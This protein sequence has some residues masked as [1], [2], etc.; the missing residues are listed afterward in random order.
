MRELLLLTVSLIV[1]YRAHFIPLSIVDSVS[2]KVLLLYAAN[3]NLIVKNCNHKGIG[4]LY[5][6]ASLTYGISGTLLSVLI[7]I[8]LFSSGNRIISPENQNFYN[9]SITSGRFSYFHGTHDELSCI[10]TKLLVILLLLQ[11]ILR[12]I[13]SFTAIGSLLVEI[14]TLLQDVSSKFSKSIGY[15]QLITCDVGSNPFCLLVSTSWLLFL[16]IYLFC[17]SL[18]IFN[19]FI[20]NEGAY[21]RLIL[22]LIIDNEKVFCTLFSLGF[23]QHVHQFLR[24]ISREVYKKY[25]ILL[26]VLFITDELL[27]N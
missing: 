14:I 21:S 24:D 19:L 2:I 18:S 16:S 27:N 8:E 3:F 12:F 26:I 7:R 1:N 25:E 6:L 13:W 20:W 15:N 23:L 4:L 11:A 17:L 22:K 9:V 5:L 10:L